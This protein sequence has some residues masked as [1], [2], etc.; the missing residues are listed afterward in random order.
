MKV[1][2]RGIQ[3]L[4]IC[5]C[6]GVLLFSGVDNKV[7]LSVGVYKALLLLLLGD[8]CG[9][10]LFLLLG[11]PGDLFLLFVFD[12]EEVLL[13]EGWL[14]VDVVGVFLSGEV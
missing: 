13:L 10:L 6:D 14:L 9:D 4:L 1:F 12:G 2:F 5:E 3:L 7:E 8:V 11:V